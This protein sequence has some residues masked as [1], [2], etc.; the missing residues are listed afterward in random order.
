MIKSGRSWTAS[1]PG[2][3][4]TSGPQQ[5]ALPLRQGAA[6]CWLAQILASQGQLAGSCGDKLVCVRAHTVCLLLMAGEHFSI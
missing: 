1:S 6:S 2:D 4:F 5:H 3:L